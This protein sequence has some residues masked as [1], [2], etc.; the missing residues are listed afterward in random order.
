[1]SSYNYLWA[2]LTKYTLRGVSLLSYKRLQQEDL[3]IIN[4]LLFK[5]LRQNEVDL[6]FKITPLQVIKIVIVI[7]VKSCDANIPFR[8]SFHVIT[9]HFFFLKWSLSSRQNAR[10]SGHKYK[11]GSHWSLSCGTYSLLGNMRR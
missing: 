10:C 1:M 9:Q 6:D 8:C 5:L 7:C 11:L 2:E 4:F 3:N